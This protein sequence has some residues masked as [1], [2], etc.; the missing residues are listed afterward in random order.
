[1]HTTTHYIM[2]PFT[3][4]FSYINSSAPAW[5]TGSTPFD[6]LGKVLGLDDNVSRLL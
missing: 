1:M 3:Q 5:P 4:F 6:H 2:E